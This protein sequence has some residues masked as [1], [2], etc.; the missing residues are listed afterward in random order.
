[1]SPV[2]TPDS[3][4]VAREQEQMVATPDTKLL[5]MARRDSLRLI[6]RST[7]VVR[8]AE[9]QPIET[10]QGAA[11]AFKEGILRVPREGDVRLEAGNLMP[12]VDVLKRLDEH[13]RNGD[14]NE[15]FWRVDPTAPAPSQ[16]ELDTLVR[17]ATELDAD[18]LQKFIDQEREGW[19]RPA[20]LETAE[21]ALTRIGKLREEADGRA[22]AAIKK[23]RA[24][25]CAE[26][27]DA[28]TDP[29]VQPNPGK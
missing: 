22:Q 26:A 5:Y 16:A 21:G 6:L 4:A 29:N 12:A 15:G 27:D 3:P 23:A 10:K 17:L 9:G 20:L 24:E 13:P 19:N 14:V 8:D 11:V 2:A 28:A 25:G 7:T 1:M 18:E